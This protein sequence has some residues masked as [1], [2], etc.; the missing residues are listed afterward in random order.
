MRA[1][2]VRVRA[3]FPAL[4]CTTCAL[5]RSGTQEPSV[6]LVP[7]RV[8]LILFQCIGLDVDNHL[9]GG[10]WERIAVYARRH[11]RFAVHGAEFRAAVECVYADSRH[12]CGDGDLG[13]LRAVTED[14]VGDFGD[15]VRD[16]DHGET[17]TAVESPYADRGGLIAERDRD[18][19]R[20]VLECRVADRRD[21]G[22]V[23]RCQRRAVLE[24]TV[25]DGGEGGRQGDILQLRAS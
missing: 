9:R 20:T 8:F 22:Q 14:V 4:P 11:H 7:L 18:Q 6:E 23:D 13:Q 21:A 10:R 25:F 19:C 16:V 5:K 2:L 3:G 24:R 15:T 1:F 12:A 17:R